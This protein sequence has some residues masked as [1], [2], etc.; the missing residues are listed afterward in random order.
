MPS[1]ILLDFKLQTKTWISL[2]SLPVKTN[3]N[4]EKEIT[5]KFLK[6]AALKNTAAENK[7]LEKYMSESQK[8]GSGLWV[9]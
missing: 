8:Y 3:E 2:Y 6:I 9:S 7:A 5:E 1:I 4:A